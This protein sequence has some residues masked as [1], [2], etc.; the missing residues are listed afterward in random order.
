MKPG[1]E[2]R[3]GTDI[4]DYARTALLALTSSPDFAWQVAGPQDWRVR[5]GDWPGTRYEAKAIREGRRCY[6]LRFRRA[7]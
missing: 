2:L 3:V 1:A 4:G 6:F 7:K 5:P